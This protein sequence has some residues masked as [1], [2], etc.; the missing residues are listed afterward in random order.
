MDQEGNVFLLQPEKH[1]LHKYFAATAYDSVLSIGGKG[2]GKEGFNFPTKISVPNRQNVF[3]LD[4]MNRRLVHLNTNLKVIDD[5]SF[6]TLELGVPE[7]ETES[8]WPISFAVGPTGE[9]FLLNQE[10]LKI[11]KLTAA[12]KLERTFAGLDYGTGSV[13]DPWD[14]TI[15]SGNLI[16]AVDS[17]EQIVSIFDLFGTYQYSL[18]IPMDFRWKRIVVFDHRI[19]FLGAHR[20]FIY[21]TFSK[22]GSAVDPGGTERLIDAAASRDF[23]YLLFENKVNLYRLSK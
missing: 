11:Y 18:S 22:Y 19:F 20:I 6:L 1:K 4:Y 9:L 16:F 14:I 2:I 8:L 23:I 3:L 5:V 13:V 15:N 10:N 12:G 7:D 17:T 21:D